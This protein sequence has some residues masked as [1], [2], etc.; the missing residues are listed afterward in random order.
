MKTVTLS[1]GPAAFSMVDVPHLVE[2]IE[3]THVNC[4][5]RWCDG[6]PSMSH[7]YREHKDGGYVFGYEG[8]LVPEPDHMP[9]HTS[10]PPTFEGS[11]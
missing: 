6:K 3:V 9:D 2:Q 8:S 4:S 5:C 1:G 11:P 10:K 7:V